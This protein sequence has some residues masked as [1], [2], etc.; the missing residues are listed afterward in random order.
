MNILEIVGK[1]S[2][3]ITLPALLFLAVVVTYIWR[4]QE[5]LFQEKSRIFDQ[6]R[7]LLRERI[8]SLQEQIPLSSEL[9]AEVKIIR[10]AA[11]ERLKSLAKEKDS[12]LD[13]LKSKS[14]E[15]EDLVNKIEDIENESLKNQTELRMI[16]LHELKVSLVGFFDS[17]ENI[18]SEIQ[19]SKFE[20]SAVN[21]RIEDI[22]ANMTKAYKIIKMLQDDEPL[23]KVA[24]SIKDIDFLLK[25]KEFLTLGKDRCQKL[26]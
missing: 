16:L 26:V 22:E 11:E 2:Q 19:N 17:F 24:S 5:K 15:N 13:Q 6:E 7:Q 21:R 25:S 14:K 9:Q 23:E 4:Q 10:T 12:L 18:A 20:S 1:V 8:K 3:V